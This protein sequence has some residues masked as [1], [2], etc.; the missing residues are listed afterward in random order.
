[1]DFMDSE[2][3]CELSLTLADAVDPLL[4]IAPSRRHFG[5]SNEP[6][7]QKGRVSLRI[8]DRPIVRDLKLLYRTTH[9][10]LPTDFEMF[11]AYN[12]W[13]VGFGL[14]ILREAGFSKVE[15]F[16]FAVT[17]ADTPRV[18]VLAVLPQTRFL[19]RAGL[20]LNMEAVLAL[21]GAAQI[22]NTAVELFAQAISLPLS[23]DASLKLSSELK[24]VG[25]L[26]FSVQTP[27][28]AAIGVGGRHAEWLFEKSAQPLVGDQQMMLTLL[29]PRAADELQTT[30]RVSVTIST[31]NLLPC[32]LEKEVSLTVPLSEAQ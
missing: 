29:A 13:L 11:T 4:T 8:G 22:P 32:R 18:T 30:L 26:S 3:S 12:V 9:N 1:M 2:S 21:N 23:A 20:D 15:R 27:V 7:L 5:K 16:G 25:N 19:K 28:I 31:F 24:M 10:Q 6:D 17:F 14:G